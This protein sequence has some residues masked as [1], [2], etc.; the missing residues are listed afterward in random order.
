[1][2]VLWKTKQAIC[3]WNLTSFIHH[4]VSFFAKFIVSAW[5]PPA[6]DGAWNIT[7]TTGVARVGGIIRDHRG[8]MKAA[9]AG[10]IQAASP[11]AAEF[12]S[13]Y[14][15][16][17]GV[18]NKWYQQKVI[19]EGDSLVLVENLTKELS[20]SCDLII[21]WKRLLNLEFH[22]WEIG[23]CRRNEDEVA[24]NLQKLN[25]YRFTTI[26]GPWIFIWIGREYFRLY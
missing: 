12:T 8:L 4:S 20:L 18:Y 1:M 26:G 15:R 10:P 19:L 21:I 14:S 22:R 23:L 9:Y 13:S 2:S 16:S 6:T 11:L 5:F 7:S 24:H 3:Q 17:S 25:F